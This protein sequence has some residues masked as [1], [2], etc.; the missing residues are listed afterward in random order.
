MSTS[1]QLATTLYTTLSTTQ[2]PSS[3][4][5]AGFIQLQ[6]FFVVLLVLAVPELSLTLTIDMLAELVCAML[7]GAMVG[8]LLF[9]LAVLQEGFLIN[10]EDVKGVLLL[11]LAILQ[12]ELINLEDVGVLLLDTGFAIVVILALREGVCLR[13]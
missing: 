6:D 3:G 9:V 1:L 10:M 8:V 11:F 13:L 7:V 4:Q 5:V 2:L 12:E